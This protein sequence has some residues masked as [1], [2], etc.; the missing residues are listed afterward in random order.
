MASSELS[1]LLTAKGNLS[2]ELQDA[3]QRVKDLSKEIKGIQA[4]GG[5]VGD[6]LAD[7]FR[8]ATQ[9][10]DKLSRK[11]GEVN[12]DV[13]RVSN[14]STSAAAKVSR[15]WQKAA[16]V[17]SN[18]LVAGLSAASLVY[19]G[20]QAINTFSEVED[21]SSALSATF[22]ASGD[23]LI[24]W[25]QASGDALNLSQMEALKAAQTFAVFG[26]SAG[27]TGQELESFTT[28]LVARAADMASFYGG[29]TADALAAISSGLMGQS[30]P[31]AKY[32]VFTQEA[33]LKQAY[34]ELTGKKVTG[35]LTQQQKVLAAH[36]VI[37]QDSARAAGDVE[38]TQ[39][40]MANQIK[41]SQQQMSDFQSTVGETIAIGLNPLLKLLNGAAKAFSS[42]PR[43]MQQVSIAVGL[44]GTAALI[45]TPRIIAL[46][47]HMATA[48]ISASGMASKM[49]GAAGIA[50]GA[51]TAGIGAAVAALMAY[52]A[53]QDETNAGIDKYIAGLDAAGNALT[54]QGMKDL[55]NALTEGI[56]TKDLQQLPLSMADITK[57]VADGGKAYDNATKALQDY[58][59]AADS[60]WGPDGEARRRTAEVMLR[61]MDTERYKL[62]QARDKW[63]MYTD[64]VEGA[65]VAS[66]DTAEAI[67]DTGDEA[68][69]AAT[70]ISALTRAMNR[71]TRVAGRQQAIRDWKK[72]LKEGI[73]KPSADTAYTA[74][75][76]FDAAFRTFKD[77]SKAQAK[78]VADN[79]ADMESVIDKSGLSKK[80]KA[81]LLAPLTAAKS[82]AQ[83]LLTE[84]KLID[85]TNVKANVNVTSTG[86][87]P[88]NPIRR[89][90][91]GLV[92][93]PGTA[94]SD[95]IPA[96]LSNGEYVIRAA[97]AR[98]LG[99]AR[100][101]RLNHA[102]KMTDPALLERL[103]ATQSGTASGPLIG[104][105]VVNNPSKDVDVEEAILRG[106][107]RA[108]R[109]KRERTTSRG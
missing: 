58:A 105:I 20:K 21:A 12:R 3:R 93:G 84:L 24:K 96:L 2:S 75:D 26:Q 67:A 95:S 15:A 57:A 98:Q 18:D 63:V 74:V 39:D 59:D 32:S 81:Q 17:F 107:A 91:G 72:A 87:A 68:D 45:V 51:F 56:D 104:S 8:Q 99:L 90:A 7:E 47:A 62:D 42:L 38:R 31:L 52:K 100:L 80:A 54:Q 41:D 50:T 33:A 108:E 65:G 60:A 46:K 23:S 66:A 35:A 82:E 70:K 36:T 94:T 19:F 40:S 97:A 43:P 78:F 69:T 5:T 6:D 29:S 101:S 102:D 44:I 76:R 14:E 83:R 9:A 106:M 64:G 89:A 49:R 16:N 55:F 28:D 11:L 86:N 34:F 73:D 88:Y 13:K 30:E 92:T 37:M 1:V 85:G 53:M 109:I 79:Y 22:G 48:G 27:L 77:G 25:A 61:Y 10:A 71:F 4:S 103:G